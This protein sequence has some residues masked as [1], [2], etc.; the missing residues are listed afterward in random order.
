VEASTA[1]VAAEVAAVERSARELCPVEVVLESII[2]TPTGNVLA[3][4]QVLGGS[5]PAAVRR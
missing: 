3:C 1:E 5:D 2:A 4:W